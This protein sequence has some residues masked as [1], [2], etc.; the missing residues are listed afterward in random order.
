MRQKIAVRPECR[1]ISESCPSELTTA[2]PPA[3]STPATPSTRSARPGRACGQSSRLGR[4]PARMIRSYRIAGSRPQPTTQAEGAGAHPAQVL[5]PGEPE[6]SPRPPPGAFAR[7]RESP[8]RPRMGLATRREARRRAGFREGRAASSLRRGSTQSVG[9][10]VTRANG[11]W[12]ETSSSAFLNSSPYRRRSFPTR[13]N[14]P[15]ADVAM[16]RNDQG[17]VDHASTRRCFRD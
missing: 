3:R 11:Q 13:L 9:W 6:D 8:G 12:V 4:D 2:H 10:V 17:Q 5:M 15:E 1:V 16:I 14:I 7:G